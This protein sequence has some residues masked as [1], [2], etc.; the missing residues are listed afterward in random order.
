M[1][2]LFWT[3]FG[4]LAIASFSS[5]YQHSCPKGNNLCHPANKCKACP[6]TCKFCQ[7]LSNSTCHEDDC[8]SCH[9]GQS[10]LVKYSDGTGPCVDNDE[11]FI[12]TCPKE[13]PMCLPGNR[14][15]TCPRGC[16]Y[17]QGS[18][19]LCTIAD[20][21][22]C[23]AHLVLKTPASSP[24]RGICRQ[25]VESWKLTCPRGIRGCSQ[26]NQCTTCPEGCHFCTA[27]NVTRCP[28]RSCLECAPGY[29]MKKAPGASLGQCVADTDRSL[30]ESQ[31][32]QQ[33]EATASTQSVGAR[34]RV[35]ASFDDGSPPI[36]PAQV[37][38]RATTEHETTITG[39]E[40]VAKTSSVYT[41][42]DKIRAEQSRAS[43]KVKLG[44]WWDLAT[45]IADGSIQLTWKNMLQTAILVVTAAMIRLSQSLAVLVIF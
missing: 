13:F 15:L 33:R 42:R 43:K 10:V 24:H 14:C 36:V 3:V 11:A 26:L 16:Q 12:A 19:T 5:S 45:A 37:R 4:L 2:K 23:E 9:S 7:N 27:H 25:P 40:D 31:P 34:G 41:W 22:R 28:T 29:R 20:C 39:D 30:G 21:T 44:S 17:C 18:G 38:N 1:F 32:R 35:A 6:S 8:M